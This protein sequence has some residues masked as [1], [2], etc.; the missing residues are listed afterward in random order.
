MNEELQNEY[1]DVD[2]HDNYPSSDEHVTVPPMKVQPLKK[3]CMTIGQLPTS[4]LETMTYYEMLLWF[5]GYL[6]DTIIPTVNNNGEALE[7]VQTIVMNLQTYINNFK[8]PRAVLPRVRERAS[9]RRYT[10]GS[11]PSAFPDRDCLYDT[12]GQSGLPE[13]APD[14][15]TGRSS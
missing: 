11:V 14:P 15:A 5:I 12:S 4:Y 2:I 9:Y 7:E 13:P 1:V 8:D 10:A 3:I 6:R